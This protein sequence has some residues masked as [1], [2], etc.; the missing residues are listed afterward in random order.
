MRG[1][2]LGTG[3]QLATRQRYP[4][5]RPRAAAKMRCRA[6]QTPS[7]VQDADLTVS[8]PS[9]SQTDLLHSGKVNIDP[10]VGRPPGDHSW[11]FCALEPAHGRAEARANIRR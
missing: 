10:R 6:S 3:V 11:L 2:D 5:Y 7:M 1:E 4:V 9:T 8:Q